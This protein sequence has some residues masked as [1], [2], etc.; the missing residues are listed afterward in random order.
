MQEQQTQSIGLIPILICQRDLIPREKTSFG[1]LILLTVCPDYG[2]TM[3]RRDTSLSEI[4]T[5]CIY[6]WLC[7]RMSLSGSDSSCT[8][9]VMKPADKG[10]WGEFVKPRCFSRLNIGRMKDMNRLNRIYGL[11]CRHCL[12]ELTGSIMWSP[13]KCR[14]METDLLDEIYVSQ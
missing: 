1:C 13:I 5:Y 9:E 7:R 6:A 10:K 14:N 2:D 4:C 8:D 12:H 11:K 3:Y